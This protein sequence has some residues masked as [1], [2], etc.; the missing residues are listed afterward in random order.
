VYDEDVR[1]TCHGISAASGKLGAVV[2]SIMMPLLLTRFGAS[3]VMIV[4][5]CVSLVG[6]LI[7]VM[8]L[9]PETHN[10]ILHKH[11]SMVDDDVHK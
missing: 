4:C 5:G 8:D 2:G 11:E 1:S 7:S 3:G 6:L 9:V 10:R